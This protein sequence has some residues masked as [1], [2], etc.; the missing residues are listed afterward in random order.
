MNQTE[1]SIIKMLTLMIIYKLPTRA[2][3]Y[4]LSRILEWKFGYYFESKR[5]LY[6]LDKDEF[7]IAYRKSVC[8]YTIE[9]KGKR[10]IKENIK[11][12]KEKVFDLFPKEI[13]FLSSILKRFDSEA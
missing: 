7:I 10:Y 4:D 3:D 8:E 1:D 11:D 6:E 9:E 12:F 5:I 13:E 2:N